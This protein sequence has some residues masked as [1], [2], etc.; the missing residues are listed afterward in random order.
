MCI[1]F[2]FTSYKLAEVLGG[3]W[4]KFTALHGTVSFLF[5]FWHHIITFA[6]GKLWQTMA[7]FSKLWQTEANQGKPAIVC[8]SLWSRYIPLGAK[9]YWDS[10][11]RAGLPSGVAAGLRL[12]LSWQSCWQPQVCQAD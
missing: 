9:L 2:F 8:H 6:K 10:I 4:L 7:N 3:L 5:L 1:V 11:I 12:R